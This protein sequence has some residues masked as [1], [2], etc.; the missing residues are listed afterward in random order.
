MYYDNYDEWWNLEGPTEEDI[1]AI[2]Q[3]AEKLSSVYE[4]F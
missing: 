1:K 4:E 3:E 2:E